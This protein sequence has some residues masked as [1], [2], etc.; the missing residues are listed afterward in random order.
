[1]V[2]HCPTDLRINCNAVAAKFQMLILG[3][4]ECFIRVVCSV[5]IHLTIIL[6]ISLH[7]SSA[8]PKNI[9]NLVL[10]QGKQLHN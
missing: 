5:R 1:M 9:H 3:L 2:I 7:K 4:S 10:S 8:M 6:F